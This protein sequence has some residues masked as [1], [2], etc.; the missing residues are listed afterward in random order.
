[1]RSSGGLETAVALKLLRSDLDHADEALHRL[2]DEAR[3]LGHLDHPAIVRA[4]DIVELSDAEGPVR[5][6]IGTKEP[7]LL[8]IEHTGRDV[9]V[10]F[11]LTSTSEAHVNCQ[12]AS[13]D[14][15]GPVTT[16]QDG[17]TV[18]VSVSSQPLP[19]GT[20]EGGI[21]TYARKDCPPP[22]ELV[23]NEYGSTSFIGSVLDWVGGRR[24]HSFRQF[25]AK[26][27]IVV[28]ECLERGVE[29]G[30]IGGGFEEPA[31]VVHEGI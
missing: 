29:P 15:D 30:Q 10:H 18:S 23:F 27:S 22:S 25:P 12:P 21:L 7:S 26:G 16:F 13:D 14:T 6:T 5:F 31:E 2:R 19:A 9:C 3:V 20:E 11:W 24:A 28:A 4:F 8:E 17:I 1:M